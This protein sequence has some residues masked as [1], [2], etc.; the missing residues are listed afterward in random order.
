M[1][2]NTDQFELIEKD[3][4]KILTRNPNKYLT[5]RYI[6]DELMEDRNI[7][8]P[9]EKENFKN[10][11]EMVLRY[12][13]AKYNQI[14]INV[15]DGVLSACFTSNNEIP[16]NNINNPYS[17]DEKYII[18]FIVDENLNKYYSKKDFRGNNILHYLVLDSD[19][20]R[21][22]K[23]FEY[24]DEYFTEENKEGITPIN[25]IKDQRISN[26]FINHLLNH[27]VDNE[28]DILMLKDALEN[29]KNGL[30]ISQILIGILY[31]FLIFKLF[32]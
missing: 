19:Y 6:H 4:I 26:L 28:Y 3:S 29:N 1:Q 20:E 30:L 21:I 18:R 14:N 13:P 27:N 24:V 31:G 22:V 11:L 7:K 17:P 32:F 25:L 5:L 16:E 9:I 2:A 23:I 10:R 15:N 12:L 8:D